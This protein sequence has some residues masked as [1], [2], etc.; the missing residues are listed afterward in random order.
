MQAGGQRQIPEQDQAL[1]DSLA[2][3]Q[4]QINELQQQKKDKDQRFILSPEQ[5]ASSPSSA[6]K[7]RRDQ[8]KRLKAGAQ[9]LPP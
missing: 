2:E 1:E 3:T 7:R 4:R 9:G 5:A 6:R 8:Q